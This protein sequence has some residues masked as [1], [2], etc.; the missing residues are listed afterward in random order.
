LGKRRAG[1]F[2]ARR[3]AKAGEF[4]YPDLDAYLRARYGEQGALLKELSREL[5]AAYTA[6]RA[7]LVRAGIPVRRGRPRRHSHDAY[8]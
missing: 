4:G 1:T 3:E 8:S 5:G 7:D 6:V 2:R